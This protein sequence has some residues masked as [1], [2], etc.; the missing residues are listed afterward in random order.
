MYD[1]F[2]HLLTFTHCVYLFFRHSLCFF[3]PFLFF[4]TM[5]NFDLFVC[6]LISQQVLCSSFNLLL[7]SFNSL[8]E[9]LS[10]HHHLS[11]DDRY[12]KPFSLLLDSTLN[13]ARILRLMLSR[14]NLLLS[15]LCYF[16]R[17]MVVCVLCHPSFVVFACLTRLPRGRIDW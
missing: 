16:L 15:R 9:L 3:G 5:C 8:V 1:A 17:S 4:S 2:F 10:W 11:P 12:V 7:F 13:Q 14:K 6:H